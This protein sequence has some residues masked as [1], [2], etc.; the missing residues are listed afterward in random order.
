MSSRA[1][2]NGVPLSTPS[3]LETALSAFAL[4]TGAV[5]VF[6]LAKL[7]FGAWREHRRDEQHRAFRRTNTGQVVF[8]DIWSNR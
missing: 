1:T 6:L 5:L 8:P 3:S 2:A 4:V 7:A